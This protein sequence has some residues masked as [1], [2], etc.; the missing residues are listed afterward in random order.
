MGG[1]ITIDSAT[2]MNKGLELIEAH[3]LFGVPVRAASTWSCTRSR[4]STRWCSSTTAPRSPT[5]AIP[6]CACRSPT[7][8]T[9]PTAPTCRC[10][11]LDLAELGQLTFEAPD[12]GT[13]PCLRLARE[14]AAAGGTAPCVLNA[15]N[16]VAVHAFLRGEL[17]FTGIAARDRVDA[18]RAAGAA[19][20]PLQRPLRGR[21]A[22]A[23]GGPGGGRVSWLLAF[24]GFALL[25][26]LHELGHFTAAKAVGMR[27]EKFSLFFPPTILQQEGG[28][29]RV[30]DRRDPRR[31]LREDQRDEPGGGP[32]RRGSRP[33]LPRAAGLEA[34]RGDRR[35]P[36]GEPRARLRAAVRLLLP[37][38]RRDQLDARSAW[39]RRATRRRSVLKPGDKLVAVDGKRGDA[40]RPVASGSRATSAPGEPREGCKAAEPATIT[41]V[42]DGQRAHV[43]ADADLRP[44]RR[45]HAA[46]LRLR[47]AGRA[48]RSRSAQ[49]LDTTADRFWFI[50]KATLEL[51]ARLI[52]PEQRKEIS[53]VVGS[54][55]VTRQTI[56]N[57]LAQVVGILAI[58]SL[59]L[60]IVNLFP[61]L[62]L[63][64]G[65]IFWAIVEKVAAQAG[66]VRR[67][68]A[69]GRGRLHA[70][71]PDLPGRP[72]ERHRPT[73][74]RGL[75]SS[76]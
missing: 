38:R 11:T 27:V 49:A 66:A 23:R 3:H 58:I 8:C 29:D 62:P 13:F 34:D 2:L 41:V 7:R 54:Y 67:D 28:G 71:D 10:A 14:A 45:A 25:V 44:G 9:T 64:G 53:G 40:G 69:G 16:E 42:R 43:R 37:D 72:V 57:D 24:V 61:F 21:R 33:R 47:A 39:S 32:P 55:E 50:T 75:P 74:G 20:A 30:R 19:G 76:L 18:G 56:L 6:T 4:S 70:R 22:G 31:R 15:A 12:A 51:P 1:K 17:S 60:A 52:N 59:S 65:H 48:R 73:V 36:G 26:I 46:R 5:S 63:D 35:G 68:G